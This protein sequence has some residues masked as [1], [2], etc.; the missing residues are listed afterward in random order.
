MRF[1]P[2]TK[3]KYPTETGRLAGGPG[4]KQGLQLLQQMP[5][6]TVQL[7]E[8]SLEMTT[9]VYP[10][11]VSSPCCAKKLRR[12]NKKKKHLSQPQR[13]NVTHKHWNPWWRFWSLMKLP[14]YSFNCFSIWWFFTNPLKK[15]MRKSNR[16]DHFCPKKLGWNFNKI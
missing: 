16:M 11:S 13:W 3:N 6:S 1:F 10:A 9:E 8:F 4:R 15:D 2:F 5:L 12:S 14:A 7:L